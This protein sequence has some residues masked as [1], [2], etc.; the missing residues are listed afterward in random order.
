[1]KTILFFLIYLLLIKPVYSQS[2]NIEISASLS[3]LSL[4]NDENYTDAFYV[5]LDLSFATVLGDKKNHQLG[6]KYKY[7]AKNPS[8]VFNDPFT[9]DERFREIHNDSYIGIF[10][11]YQKFIYDS[12][13]FQIGSG[14]HHNSSIETKHS[15][16]VY[17]KIDLKSSI[18]VNTTLGFRIKLADYT[19]LLIKGHLGYNK[20][21]IDDE[22]HL[23]KIYYGFVS[24]LSFHF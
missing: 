8:F 1:M 9:G 6:L 22:V 21:S 19:G 4:I 24:G 10:W 7:N 15:E 23:T 17:E 20:N 12:F 3:N 5:P 18:G 16:S 2:F 14:I 13:I 11:Q